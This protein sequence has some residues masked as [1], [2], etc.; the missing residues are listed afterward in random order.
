[1]QQ[2]LQQRKLSEIVGDLGKQFKQIRGTL[3]DGENGRCV[4][5][6]IMSYCGWDG[7]DH[8]EEA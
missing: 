6:G 5:G 2:I 8:T 4:I 1:M 7:D 3:S